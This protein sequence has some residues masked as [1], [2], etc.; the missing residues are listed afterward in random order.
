MILGISLGA[1]RTA[2]KANIAETLG[3][4]PEAAQIV[5]TAN[6]T[7]T[8][9]AA[10]VV[11]E[12]TEDTIRASQIVGAARIAKTLKAAERDRVIKEAAQTD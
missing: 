6:I 2:S 8:Q 12:A 10:P 4:A 9:I 7:G 5:R 1:N 11:K 3:T